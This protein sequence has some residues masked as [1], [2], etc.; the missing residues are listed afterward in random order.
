MNADKIQQICNLN[1][2]LFPTIFHI[3]YFVSSVTAGGEY[4]NIK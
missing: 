1:N 4:R 2:E 3:E